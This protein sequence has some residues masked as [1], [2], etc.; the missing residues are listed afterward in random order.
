MLRIF[1]SRKAIFLLLL[2]ILAF[3]IESKAKS[4]TPE[5]DDEDEDEEEDENK[6]DGE[7]NGNGN[8]ALFKKYVKELNLA[9]CMTKSKCVLF[10]EQMTVLCGGFKNFSEIRLDCKEIVNSKLFEYVRS[11]YFR[12]A[13]PI[14]IDSSFDPS[15]IKFPISQ[16]SFSDTNGIEIVNCPFAKIK[17]PY[18]IALEVYKRQELF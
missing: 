12:P 13:V 3:I 4:T 18:A 11:I 10:P 16:F 8:E 5:P 2:I 14:K 7:T 6:G 15:K 9:P 1:S 17:N